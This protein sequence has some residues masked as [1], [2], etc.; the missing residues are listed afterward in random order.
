MR[1]LILRHGEAV[2]DA[3]KLGDRA[4]WLTGK[5]RRRT[6]EVASFL[7]G[8]PGDSSGDEALRKTIGAGDWKPREIWTSQLVR[9]VQTAEILALTVGLEGGV[10]VE[11][12]LAP[13]ESPRGLA[14]KLRAYDGDASVLALV[15]HE[16]GLSAVA[17]ELLGE[18]LPFDLNKSGAV[19]LELAG[20]K[21]D[22]AKLVF[23]LKPKNLC[24]TAAGAAPK[25]DVE[26][27]DDA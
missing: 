8:L 12:D 23:H 10:E 14:K 11:G 13:D 1:I 5:G 25:P 22:T 3:G 18:A 27:D 16:P 17:R 19:G 6:R 21:R 7:A 9:A 15:G 4:R 2:D 26:S 24:V 20:D